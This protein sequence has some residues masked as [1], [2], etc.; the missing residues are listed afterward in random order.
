MGRCSPAPAGMSSR[1]AWAADAESPSQQ[2]IQGPAV[3]RWE[4][5]G[6]LLSAV[7]KSAKCLNNY[8]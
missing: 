3:L 8:F 5:K 4:R 6:K 7:L 2:P 1:V